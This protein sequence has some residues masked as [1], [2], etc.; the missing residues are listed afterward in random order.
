MIIASIWNLL[1]QFFP[2]WVAIAILSI[3]TL[4]LVILVFKL[5]GLLLDA[6][7]FV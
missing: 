3:I 6:I 5:I 4:L 1:L 7:P 2:A